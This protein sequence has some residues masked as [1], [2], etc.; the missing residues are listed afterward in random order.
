MGSQINRVL[1]NASLS[2]I[3]LFTPALLFAQSATA[4]KQ[5]KLCTLGL[6][7]PIPCP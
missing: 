7:V 4:A 1:F 6:C 5:C 3:L 2:A